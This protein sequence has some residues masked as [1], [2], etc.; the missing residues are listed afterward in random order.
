M[1]QPE[2]YDKEEEH[3]KDGKLTTKVKANVVKPCN[4]YQHGG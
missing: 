1:Y 4:Y 3:N 2:M